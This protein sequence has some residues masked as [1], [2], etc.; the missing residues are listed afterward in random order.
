M[1]VTGKQQRL[2][3]PFN[4]GAALEKDSFPHKTCRQEQQAIRGIVMRT[5]WSL[6]IHHEDRDKDSFISEDRFNNFQDV[7][8]RMKKNKG[9]LFVVKIPATA[10]PM[11]I[12]AIHNLKNLGY[13]L[14]TQ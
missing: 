7:H 1:P 5:Q 14:E 8:E 2:A 12:Q 4:P 3:K 13:R 10:K 11:E 6:A 9:R